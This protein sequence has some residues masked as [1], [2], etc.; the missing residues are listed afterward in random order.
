M[1]DAQRV[2]D[3]VLDGLIALLLADDAIVAPT[4]TQ[5][6]LCVR[7]TPAGLDRLFDLKQRPPTMPVSL[8][9][10]DRAQAEAWVHLPPWADAFLAAFPPAALTLLAPARR[11]SDPRLGGD[12][13]AVRPVIHPTLRTLVAEVGPVTVTSANRSGS[14]PL[15]DP[16][17]A[18]ESLGLTAS[19]VAPGTAPGGP[20]STLVRL[21]P[22]AG[23]SHGWSASVIRAGVVPA[24]AVSAWM[25]STGD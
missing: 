11:P 10:L 7:P 8:G 25:T 6:A 23:A 9:V 19:H 12:A 18:A 14:D 5:P 20:P 4:S 16:G 3:P 22:D 13:I 2:L 21:A 17:A 24:A 15:D 1:S